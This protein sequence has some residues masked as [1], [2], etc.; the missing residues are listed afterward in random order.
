MSVAEA[1]LTNLKNAVSRLEEAAGMERMTGLLGDMMRD[2]TIQRFKF[3]LEVAWKYLR[4]LLHDY[5]VQ[6]QDIASPK[7]VIREALAN[8]LICDGDIWIE[9]I[10][11]RNI[12]SHTY[13]ADTAALLYEK[14]TDKYLAEFKRLID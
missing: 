5:G 6:A 7:K 1:K 3:V 13:S 8:G 12:L 9:M 2:A 10:P 4:Y 14:I 11:D